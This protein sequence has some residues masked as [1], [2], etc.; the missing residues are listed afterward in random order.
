MLVENDGRMNRLKA[1]ERRRQRMRGRV[2]V[3]YFG[4]FSIRST[5]RATMSSPTGNACC[6]RLRREAAA[7]IP[8]EIMSFNG[9]CMERRQQTV[10]DAPLQAVGVMHS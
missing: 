3:C 7:S 10:M 5:H 9:C 8:S 2:A 4:A 6:I 1:A